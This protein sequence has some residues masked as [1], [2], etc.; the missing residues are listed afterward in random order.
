MDRA[1]APFSVDLTGKKAY[2]CTTPG[3]DQV[4]VLT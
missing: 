2:L 4:W 3:G 1:L